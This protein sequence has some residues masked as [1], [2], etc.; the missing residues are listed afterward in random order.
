Q[1]L[2]YLRT[3]EFKPYVIYVKPPT[4]A[5]LKETRQA[6]HAMSTF[7]KNSSRGFTDEELR[8]ML[9]AAAR[10]EFHYSHWFDEVIV[11]DDLSTSFERLVA[12]IQKVESDPLWV[13]ASW[14]Q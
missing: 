8:L 6:A 7:D 9:K 4:L 11:N 14:V 5:V 3:C 1:A 12:A 2:K 13:P 10:I